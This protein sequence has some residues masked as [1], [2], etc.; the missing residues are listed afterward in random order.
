[1]PD[2]APF[3]QY[4]TGSD[5]GVLFQSSKRLTVPRKSG[6]LSFQKLYEGFKGYS[7]HVYTADGRK[8][9]ALDVQTTGDGKVYTLN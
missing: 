9:N 6:I 4:R 1:V 8:E 2:W 5:I 7:L 3:V